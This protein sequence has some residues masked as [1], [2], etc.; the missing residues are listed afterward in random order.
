[1]N[2]TRKLSA[3]EA[4]ILEYSPNLKAGILRLNGSYDRYISN[5]HKNFYDHNGEGKLSIETTHFSN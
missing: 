2:S 1:M 5:K 4:K 3:I